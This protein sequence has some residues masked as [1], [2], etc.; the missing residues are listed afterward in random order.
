[1]IGDDATAVAM[2]AAALRRFAVNKSVVRL[3]RVQLGAQP[4]DLLP[5]ALQATLPHLNSANDGS[6][7]VV[8]S[9]NTCHAPVTSPEELKELLA[10]LI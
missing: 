8:C 5:P 4:L 3:K 9:G 2:E 7:A 6:F 1:M 10:N